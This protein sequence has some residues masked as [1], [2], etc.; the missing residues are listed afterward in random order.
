MV[1]SKNRGMNTMNDMDV[2][3]VTGIYVI[4][5]ML[6]AFVILRGADIYDLQGGLEQ[7]LYFA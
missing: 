4:V 3:L 6:I 2:V 1:R 7:W 5:I